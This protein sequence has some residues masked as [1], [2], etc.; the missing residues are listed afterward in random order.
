MGGVVRGAG[1]QMV[2]AVSYLVGYY[3]IGLPIAVSLMFP[4][5]MCILGKALDIWRLQ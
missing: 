2:G 3:I 5:K 1:K 4:F